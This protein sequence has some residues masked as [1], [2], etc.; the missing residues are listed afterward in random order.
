MSDSTDYENN[1]KGEKIDTEIPM[2][3]CNENQDEWSEDINV[4]C[5]DYQ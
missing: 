3:I 2:K 1:E 4:Y 5:P